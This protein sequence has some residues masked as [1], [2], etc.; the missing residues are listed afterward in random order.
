MTGWR[1][2]VGRGVAL[3]LAFLAVRTGLS[4][5]PPSLLVAP[6][7][8]ALTGVTVIN[9][10]RDRHQDQTLFLRGGRIESMRAGVPET[11]LLPRWRIF[12]GRYVL[13]GVIDLDARRLPSIDHLQRM[14]GVYFLFGGVTTVRV[15][16]G[17]DH[18]LQLQRRIDAGEIPGPRVIACGRALEGD[19]PACDAVHLLSAVPPAP[20]GQGVAVRL[21]GWEQLDAAGLDALVHSA[22]ARRT[23][24]IPNL[25]RWHQLTV[26]EAARADT[27][28]VAFM[29]RFYREVIWPSEAA[30]L[31]GAGGGD[32]SAIRL[33]RAV[34]MMEQ[35]V[36]RLHEAGVAI[37]LG[38]ATPS[39]FV[40]PGVGALQEIAR[41]AA[42]GFTLEEAWV[43]ATRT[44]G[45][46]LGIPQ[47][48]VIEEG[49][50]ADLL[51]FREDPTQNPD[52]ILTLEAVVTQGRLYPHPLLGGYVMEYVRYTRQPVYEWLSTVLA[53]LSLWWRDA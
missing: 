11:S 25:F 5:W 17:S 19:P 18:L 48:G 10:G 50:P 43:A 30:Q 26:S 38:S 34:T 22:A 9:P 51:V 52:A 33:A 4:L 3:L 8:S 27:P 20:P 28:G 41:L 6:D 49:A 46:A 32:P 21:Q 12:K 2:R 31:A 29:P 36:R 1:R 47:L 44:A 15:F 35:A 24:Y 23:A 16:D 42:A 39:P 14:F 45:E 40:T 7:A 13:P 53:R 37:H